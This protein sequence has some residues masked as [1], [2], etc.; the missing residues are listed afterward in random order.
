MAVCKQ[1]FVEKPD[2]QFDRW[3]H[4]NGKSGQYKSCRSCKTAE[5]KAW[6]R[7]N[8]AKVAE[9]S[10][11]YKTLH[12]DRVKISRAKQLA[13]ANAEF[14]RASTLYGMARAEI[15]SIYENQQT[16][17]I[18]NAAQSRGKRKRLTIDHDHATGEFRG[19]LCAGCN[20]A[21]GLFQDDPIR[22]LAAVR[23]IE[24][25]NDAPSDLYFEGHA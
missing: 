9:Y 6:R 25:K 23:Y 16:C 13:K 3:S 20:R 4:K 14:A 17:E 22:M 5:R 18:C 7:R 11:R 24:K 19:L 2:D 12:P 10:A 1:C 8:P 21:I 15:L